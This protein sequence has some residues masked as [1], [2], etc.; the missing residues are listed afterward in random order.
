MSRHALSTQQRRILAVIQAD[1][2]EVGY[3]PT[4]REIADRLGLS[5][6]AGVTQH[7]A[8]MTRKGFVGRGS[9]RSARAL[10]IVR[11][12]ARCGSAFDAADLADATSVDGAVHCAACAPI[13]L[14]ASTTPPLGRPA[15]RR[16]TR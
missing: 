9:I 2:A 14:L 15:G 6:S 3:P 7:L 11:A 10:W 5:S 12:C 8:A 16:T 4:C 1:V 13:A